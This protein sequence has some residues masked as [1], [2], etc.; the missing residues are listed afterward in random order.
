MRI[1]KILYYAFLD[2]NNLF[3][4]LF[5]FQILD[6]LLK[7][8]NTTSTI[9]NINFLDIILTIYNFFFIKIPFH[10]PAFVPNNI[11]VIFFGE[12]S[13]Y[14]KDKNELDDEGRCFIFI[15]GILG[16]KN[17]VIRTKSKL[18]KFLNKP[19]NIL[20]NSTDTI[21]GDVIEAFIGKET[22]RLTES[23][24]IALLTI[25]SKLLDEKI[26]KVVIIAYS[27]GT[28]IISNVLDNLNKLGIN[29]EKILQKLEIY[30]FSNCSSK[31]KYIKNELPYIENFANE[32]DFI[33]KLGCNCPKQVQ[34]L[35]NIDGKIFI[36]K[37]KYGHLFT[38]HYINNFNKDY[39]LS[40]L[41]NYL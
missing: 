26:K 20:F 6:N 2:T 15:N 41:N 23:S 5:G 11:K 29:D 19:V 1:I 3:R 7:Y 8:K 9:K 39:P 33:G 10:C 18:Q 13:E 34:H 35:V 14:I 28:I 21:F 36:N 12:K 37:N 24:T 30:C 27:Q 22:N 32:H 17:Q 40:N 31:T 25:S 38:F 4:S 16:T